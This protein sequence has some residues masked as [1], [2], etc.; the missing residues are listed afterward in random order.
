VYSIKFAFQV[1]GESRVWIYVRTFESYYFRAF[2][3]V[4]DL[5]VV[6]DILEMLRTGR[7]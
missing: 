5:S 6:I 2:F 4:I 7:Y 1:S 3:Y